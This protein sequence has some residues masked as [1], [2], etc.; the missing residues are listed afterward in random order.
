MML[1]YGDIMVIFFMDIQW[2]KNVNGNM[3]GVEWGCE[4]V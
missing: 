4:W 1:V 2:E 3:L